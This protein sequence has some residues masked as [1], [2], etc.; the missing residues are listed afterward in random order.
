[1]GVLNF[2]ALQQ[3]D[4]TRD[5]IVHGEFNTDAIV[6]LDQLVI[7][8]AGVHL[9]RQLGR[10]LLILLLLTITYEGSHRQHIFSKK[11]YSNTTK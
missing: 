4:L 5:A 1:M 10:A 2:A 8:E 7:A 6:H 9:Y 3:V 11:K